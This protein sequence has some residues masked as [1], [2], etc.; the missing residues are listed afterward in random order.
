MSSFND[1]KDKEEYYKKT[2]QTLRYAFFEAKLICDNKVSRKSSEF[3]VASDIA[4]VA[5]M[6]PGVG[7]FANIAQLFITAVDKIDEESIKDKM[8][9]FINFANN[10]N[11]DNKENNFNE[12]IKTVAKL[13]TQICH[14]EN[15]KTPLDQASEDCEKIIKMIYDGQFVSLDKEKILTKIKNSFTENQSKAENDGNNHPK[16]EDIGRFT[17]KIISDGVTAEKSINTK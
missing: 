10:F 16:H 1:D 11:G 9:N 13:I 4:S 2:K 6:I 5:S 15:N 14:I 3:D 17:H 12:T 8:K 7:S